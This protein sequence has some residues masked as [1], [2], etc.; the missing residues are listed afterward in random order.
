MMSSQPVPMNA[1]QRGLRLTRIRGGRA[2]DLP[3][4]SR[5]FARA[6]TADALPRIGE[7]E[8]CE[9]ARRCRLIVLELNPR[10]LAAVACITGRGIVFVV[11]D[12]TAGSAEL[13]RRMSGVA[14]ALVTS[15]ST[16]T[17]R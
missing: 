16:I 12:P 17:M 4:I 11:V 2:S 7:A 13:E 10:E 15:E 1:T 9:L 6:N 3:A 14:E 5:L 8:L